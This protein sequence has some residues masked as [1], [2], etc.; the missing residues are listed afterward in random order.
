MLDP[1]DMPLVLNIRPSTVR[2]LHALYFTSTSAVGLRDGRQRQGAFQNFRGSLFQVGSG[3][4]FDFLP[5]R[6]YS[7]N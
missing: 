4:P 7:R 5:H 6:I 2:A 3:H 1:N